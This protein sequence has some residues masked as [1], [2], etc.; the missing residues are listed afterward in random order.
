MVLGTDDWLAFLEKSV[1]AKKKKKK[2]GMFRQS[3]R[4]KYHVIHN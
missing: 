3:I 4:G 1:H 2:K